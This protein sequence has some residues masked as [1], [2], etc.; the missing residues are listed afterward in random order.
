MLAT[1][2]NLPSSPQLVCPAGSLRALTVAVDAGANAV[3]LGL[4]DATN[5]RNF[6]GLNFDETQIREGIAY[7]HRR[8]AQVLMALNT[9]AD[10]RS[11]EPWFAAAD[12]A[13]ELGADAL[14]VADTA[15]MGHCVRHLPSLRLHL[16]VQASA[17]SHAAI[18]FYRQRYG[19][20]RAVLPRVV[21]ADQIAKIIEGTSV[22]I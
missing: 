20:Q 21:A 2:T 14:I 18:E 16:S 6:A 17:T 12:K 9:F 3:Y 7:A 22:E 19:V 5:A 11:P 8:G 10:A 15:V 13:A 1:H 4:K